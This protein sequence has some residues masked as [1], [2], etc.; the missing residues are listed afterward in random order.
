MKNKKISY[1]VKILIYKKKNMERRGGVSRR[2][3]GR[4][5]SV[6]GAAT[7]RERTASLAG[8]LPMR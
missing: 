8:P 2:S 5:P 1:T 6:S 4:P 7:A 3:V